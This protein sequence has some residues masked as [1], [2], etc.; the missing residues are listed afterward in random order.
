M[1]N[2]IAEKN[3][4]KIIPKMKVAVSIDVAN[5][6]VGGGACCSRYDIMYA[7][8][9]GSKH[10]AYKISRYLIVLAIF[11]FFTCFLLRL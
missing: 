6:S 1:S 4:T 2:N 9:V 10:K 7:A 5:I 11:I 3:I 8:V